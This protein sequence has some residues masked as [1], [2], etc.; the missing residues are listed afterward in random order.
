MGWTRETSK[1]CSTQAHEDNKYGN[2]HFKNFSKTFSWLTHRGCVLNIPYKLGCKMQT[3][4]ARS[5]QIKYNAWTCLRV[6]V[7]FFC[8]LIKC[9]KR[10]SNWRWSFVWLVWYCSSTLIHVQVFWLSV[11]CTKSPSLFYNLSY[12]QRSLSS[13]SKCPFG[14]ILI[15]C[16]KWKMCSFWQ[17]CLTHVSQER[18]PTL[19][20]AEKT[21]LSHHFPALLKIL[22]C[23]YFHGISLC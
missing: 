19:L 4:L 14:V 12:K 11:V 8:R 17:Q 13:L 1:N 7:T 21:D 9:W 23:S 20:T 2:K 16:E 18:I 5:N 22:L 6:A 15:T 10:C 3:K